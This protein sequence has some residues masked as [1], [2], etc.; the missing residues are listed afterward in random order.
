MTSIS[1]DPPPNELIKRFALI[2]I[3]VFFLLS[4]VLFAVVQFDRT[5]REKNVEVREA[6]RIQVAKGGVESDLASAEADLRIIANMP[7]LQEFLDTGDNRLKRMIEREFLVFAKETGDYDQIRYLDTSG[8]EVIRINYNNGKPYVVPFNKLQN[9]FG[10][11]YFTD[12]FKIDRGEIFVSPLDLNVEN[13]KVEIPYKPMIRYG[14]PVFDSTGEKKGV[15]LLNYFGNELLQRFRMAMQ[16]EGMHKAMLL[17]RN[18]YWLSSPDS[19]EEW[20]FMLGASDHTFGNEYP[21]VW[22]IIST[23]QAGSVLTSKGLFV[24]D[25]VH[26]KINRHQA[27]VRITASG[28]HGLEDEDAPDYRWKIVSFTSDKALFGSAFYTQDLGKALLVFVYILF[29]LISL[30][31]ARITLSRRQAREEVHLLN[32]ELERQVIEHAQ[33]EEN[34][35]VTLNSIGD[36]VMSTDA[37]GRITRLNPVAEQLTGWTSAD[38]MQKPI[39]DIFRLVNQTTHQHVD[40][41]VETMLKKGKRCG[42]TAD[43]VLISRDGR[44]VPIADSCAPIRNSEGEIIGAVLVFRDVSEEQAAKQALV[45][46]ASRI[47]A[48]L[49]TV[50]DGIISL[51]EEGFIET[52][53]PATEALFGYSS[54][55]IL[56]RN[57]KVLLPEAY[58]GR[59]DRYLANFSSKGINQNPGVGLDIEGRRKNGSNFPMFFAIGKMM[60]GG[61]CHFTGIV[62]DI[63][64]RK[65]AEQNLIDAKEQAELAN[66]TKDS[67]LATM[68][69]EIRT[70]LTGMLGMLEVL[71]MTALTR[72][73]NETLQAAWTSGRSLLRIVSDILDW[74]KIED[75]KL[76]IVSVS[77]SIFNLLQEVVNTYSRSASAKGLILFHHVDDRLSQAHIVDVLRLSQVLNNFVSNAI[78][79]T[80]QGEVEVRADLIARHESGE[81][82][83]FSVRDTGIGI[84][85]EAQKQLFQRY[86]QGSSDTARLYGGTGLGLAI[87]RCLADL[88]DGHVDLESTPGV[89]STFSFTLTLPISAEQSAETPHLHPEVVEQRAVTPLF[90]SADEEQIPLVL[91]V[92]DHPINRAVLERQL[93]LL[94]LRVELAE[95]GKDA[96][97]QWKSKHFDLIVSD[98]HMPEMDGYAFSREVRRI[99]AEEGLTRI[100]IL[101]WTANALPEELEKCQVAGMDELVVKPTDIRQLKKVLSKWFADRTVRLDTPSD[102]KPSHDEAVVTSVQN[103]STM[104]DDTNIIDYTELEKIVPDRSE[105]PQVLQDFLTHIRADY[106]KLDEVLKQGDQQSVERAAHRMKGSSRMVGASALADACAEIEQSARAGDISGARNVQP[107]LQASIEQLERFLAGGR[108]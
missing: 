38:A 7:L 62:R 37:Q 63:S 28:S 72:E 36:A 86:R 52:V 31:V 32:I 96:L 83:R 88:M 68:S 64:E 30:Y 77:T 50:A 34:L 73:Q 106:L 51:N 79:F 3:P 97:N 56:G 101:A 6:S 10:R 59:Y 15:V 18:G 57:I 99:E 78:K 41:P 100:P 16:S 55:E 84:S 92:D 75:G 54:K 22:K 43:S 98:C 82:I 33:G 24:Y 39:T 35:S 80:S 95:N 11:Y 60:Q 61:H 74:S 104:I 5:L 13:N 21:S 8:K 44:E 93:K 71:S 9:K 87:C 91:G 102:S 108:S 67:F 69:H 107:A 94:G 25:T 48:I 53:N 19:K 89:G 42:L 66:R 105:H 2:Y 20:G 17:N 85:P 103:V 26:S 14:T 12:A 90:D 49:N 4:V 58:H 81:E 29:A 27:A 46:S 23:T 76:E 1:S 40:G 70:P 47:K 45:D 65:N